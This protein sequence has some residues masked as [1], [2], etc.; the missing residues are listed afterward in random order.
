MMP[1]IVSLTVIL[2]TTKEEEILLMR[3]AGRQL[4]LFL[5]KCGRKKPV[6]KLMEGLPRW[7]S[8]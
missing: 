5:E 4:H 1:V 2:H 7:S 3:L 8:S 6:L